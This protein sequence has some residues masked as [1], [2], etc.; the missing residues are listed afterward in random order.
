MNKKLAKAMSYVNE[1]YIAQ[2]ALRKKRR[3]RPLILAAAAIL[4]AVIL[5]NV[6]SIPLALSAR[7]VSIA[8]ESRKTDRPNRK[9]DDYQLWLEARQQRSETVERSRPAVAEFARKGSGEFL[10]GDKNAL[11]SPVNAYIALGM[12]AEL[13][14]SHTQQSVLEL[15]GM[16]NTDQLRST[17]SA[18]WEELYQ[19]EG[20]EISILANSLWLDKEVDFHQPVMDDLAYHYYADVYQ[21]DLQGKG[22]GKAVSRWIN[23]QTG[24]MLDGAADSG[25]MMENT[26]MALVSTIYFRSQWSSKFNRNNNTQGTFQGIRGD[27]ECT[28]MNKKEAEMNYYW[29]EDYGAVQLFLKNDCSMWFILPDP[30]KGIPDVLEA[31][32]YMDMISQSRDFPADNHK[33]MKVNLSVPKFDV[34]AETDLRAGLENLGLGE[35][36]QFYG[37]DFSSS[38]GSDVPVYLENITQNTRITVEEEGVTAASYIKLRFGAGAAA[39]PEEIIDFVL[40]RPFLFA[41]SCNGIPMFM[42][43]VQMP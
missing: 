9:S 1:K 2:A 5:F 27:I 24:G 14:G 12:T 20:K 3:Y 11:W 36:F 23:T 39:P 42:G 41:I 16:E 43:T 19:K 21:R 8:S 32:D 35:L 17:V 13:T 30:D 29:A 25:A 10:P 33:W 7:A 34:S 18:V 38:V 28:F 31:G 26:M 37:N 22:T 4:A 40:D 6:P 15:L